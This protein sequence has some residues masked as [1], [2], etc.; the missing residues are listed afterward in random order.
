MAK[1]SLSCRVSW[2]DENSL[3][4]KAAGGRLWF[5]MGVVSH[6]NLVASFDLHKNHVNT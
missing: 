5:E 4:I 1:L 6:S 3:M 2:S